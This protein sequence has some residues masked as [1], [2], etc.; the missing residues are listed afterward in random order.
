MFCE[1]I[2]HLSWGEKG[3]R[4]EKRIIKFYLVKMD[5]PINCMSLG[6]E[7][8]NNIIIGNTFV[9]GVPKKVTP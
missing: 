2:N 1:G 9:L 7:Y 4:M 3:W 5:L 6:T 8:S